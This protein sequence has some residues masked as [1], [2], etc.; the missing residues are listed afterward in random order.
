[1]GDAQVIFMYYT[2]HYTVKSCSFLFEEFFKSKVKKSDY[3]QTRK[4]EGI[5]Q[6][7]RDKNSLRTIGTQF[8]VKNKESRPKLT[9]SLKKI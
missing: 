5:Y 2:Y 6:R 7:C 8:K 3:E 9:G 4:A 1:M